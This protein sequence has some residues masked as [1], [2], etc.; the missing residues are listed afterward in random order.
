MTIKEK[1]R[2]V[3]I[4]RPYDLSDYNINYDISKVYL[5]YVKSKGFVLFHET[6]YNTWLYS[7]E[8]HNTDTEMFLNNWTNTDKEI[9][10][11]RDIFNTRVIPDYIKKLE[12]KVLDNVS[13]ETFTC[14][15][16]GDEEK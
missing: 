5:A 12:H 14:S 11:L 16:I 4:T 7:I 10:K 15:I 1:N 3:M 13:R 8:E 9:V 2:K 6:D